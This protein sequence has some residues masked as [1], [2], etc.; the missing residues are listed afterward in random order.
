MDNLRNKTSTLFAVYSFIIHYQLS[1]INLFHYQFV[2]LSIY[3]ILGGC[4]FFVRTEMPSSATRKTRRAS[5]EDVLV[6]KYESK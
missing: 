1:I 6:G 2:S 3:L 5:K 4:A